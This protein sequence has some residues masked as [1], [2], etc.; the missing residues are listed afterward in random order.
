M[1]LYRVTNVPVRDPKRTMVVEVDGI[2]NIKIWNACA[3]DPKNKEQWWGITNEYVSEHMFEPKNR[4]FLRETYGHN[5]IYMLEKGIDIG[6]AQAQY[7]I[8][9]ALGIKGR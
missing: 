8:R 3:K 7:D 9:T 4:L 1:G 6:Y 2:G 5:L